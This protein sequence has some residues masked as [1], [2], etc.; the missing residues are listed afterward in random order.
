MYTRRNVM[1]SLF[2][3]G[4]LLMLGLTI[5]GLLRDEQETESVVFSVGRVQYV[6][7]GAFADLPRVVPAQELVESPFVL[8][9]QSNIPTEL[10]LHVEIDSP[11][12]SLF[13]VPELLELTLDDAWVLETDGLYYYRGV[14]TDQTT[15]PGKAIIPI[16][17]GAQIPVVD[18]MKLLGET[19]RNFASGMPFS[20]T[21]RFE[22]KQAA[23]VNWQVLGSGTY[24]FGP[25]SST[26]P[27]NLVEV[28]DFST[29]NLNDFL[30]NSWGSGGGGSWSITAEGLR[31][32][33]QATDLVFYP[34][35]RS[36]YTVTTRFQMDMGT[37]GGVGIFFETVLNEANQN[38]DTGYIVQYDRGFSE[39]VLRRRVNGGESTANILA[40]IG[41]RSTSTIINPNIPSNQNQAWWSAE[42]TLAI[43]VRDANPGFKTVTIAL[44]GDIIL[45]NFPIESTIAPT[46]N[47][48]GFRSWNNQPATYFET[49]IEN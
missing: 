19:V 17:L 42:R 32:T 41:N 24:D 4:T 23:F 43:T 8:I 36:Q 44:D 18:S 35:P 30:F 40:R 20:I 49:I 13:T 26:L 15:E 10:R 34:N 12:M 39:I 31:S 25:D 2:L 33:A 48:T 38:R 47:V 14:E 9:N 22:A 1:S 29:F 27:D 21:F 46:D 3:I 28:L 37:F 11:L 6:W 16:N 7:Q 5:W 45:L